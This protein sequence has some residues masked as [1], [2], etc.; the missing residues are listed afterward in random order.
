MLKKVLFSFL[1][2]ILVSG[3]GIFLA[4]EK[5]TSLRDE[6]KLT[7][8]QMKRTDV[9]ITIREGL[10]REEIAEL[11]EKNTICTAADFLSLTTTKEGSLFP[12]TYRFFPNTPALEVVKTLTQQFQKKA[13][14]LELTE[15]QLILA[16][17]VER[18]APNSDSERSLI[19]G[20]YTNRLAI[21]MKLDADPTVQYARDSASMA[22]NSKF[23]F[24]KPITQE[25]YSNIISPY[26]TYL[27]PGLPPGP[28]A[29]PGQKSL[30]AARNPA[31]H[32]Y[33]YFLHKNGK[34][35]L[36]TTFEEHLRNQQ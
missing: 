36:A 8:E 34:L 13:G 20:V 25:N 30:L 33:L 17:I 5:I 6:K 2:V 18:E 1:V 35:L 9:S 32:S 14:A 16:S 24:W 29:N 11:L 15:K 23:S 10:R 4:T 21:G 3:V 12:D 27:Q 19:A 28:I 22:T 31:K 26:N 7:V